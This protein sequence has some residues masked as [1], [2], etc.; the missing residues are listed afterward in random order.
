MVLIAEEIRS[1]GSYEMS[2]LI[3]K[4]LLTKTQIWVKM[5]MILHPLAK[6]SGLDQIRLGG[7]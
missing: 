5:T 7:M 3:L 2:N 6:K 4:S 1:E